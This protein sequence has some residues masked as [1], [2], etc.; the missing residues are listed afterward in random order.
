[1]LSTTGIVDSLG[2]RAAEQLLADGVCCG[3]HYCDETDS[4][5]S[6][7]LAEINDRL[8]ADKDCPK[9]YLTDR[10][11]AGRGRHGREWVSNDGT[12][13]FSLVINRR[14]QADRTSKL[15]SLAVGVGIARGLDF[16]FAPI[17][18]R[19]KWPNDVYLGGGKVAGVLL[20]TNQS[21]SDRI[22]IGVGVNVG[23]APDLG[24]DPAAKH[25]QSVAQAVGRHVERYDL[26]EPI[27][28]NIQQ[29]FRLLDEDADELIAEFRSKCLLTGQT[30]TFQERHNDNV[31]A[32]RG[33]SDD[34]EL[35][36]ETATGQRRLQSGEARLVRL[37]LGD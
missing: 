7:A 34:G 19:L 18:A 6:L 22:V 30:V 3:V 16:E 13:T 32:C 9:L 37:R 8:I 14:L 29:A 1:M 11:T 21:V 23:E 36:V 31:G 4:T 5:N 26:L 10:Q 27:V 20:E 25:V 15:I 33:V 24:D 28:V 35:I 2:L 12:L 17:Q